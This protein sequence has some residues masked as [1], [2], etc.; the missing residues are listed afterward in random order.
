MIGAS[1][2]HLCRYSKADF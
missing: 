2:K 1:S